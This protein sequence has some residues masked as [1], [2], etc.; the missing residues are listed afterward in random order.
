MSKWVYTSSLEETLSLQS[1]FFKGK[2]ATLEQ[3]SKK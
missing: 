3:K 1:S 2:E